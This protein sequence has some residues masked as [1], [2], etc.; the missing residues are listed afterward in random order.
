MKNFVVD[1]DSFF[2]GGAVMGFVITLVGLILPFPSQMTFI[3]PAILSSCVILLGLIG[4]NLCKKGG[5][6]YDKS[7]R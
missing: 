1:R 3:L 7:R 2:I 4:I 6:K 5:H